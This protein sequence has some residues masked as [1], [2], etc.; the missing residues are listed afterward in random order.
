MRGSRIAARRPL[1]SDEVFRNIDGVLDTILSKLEG[2]KT[3]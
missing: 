2:R 1:W 3:L